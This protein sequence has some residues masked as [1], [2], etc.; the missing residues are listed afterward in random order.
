MANFIGKL[1]LRDVSTFPPITK[2]LN[3]DFSKP[4]ILSGSLERF[5]TTECFDIAEF[6]QIRSVQH[7]VLNSW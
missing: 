2:H 1:A 3:T 7:L 5:L 6:T 4:E